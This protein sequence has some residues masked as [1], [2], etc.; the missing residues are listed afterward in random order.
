[1]TFASEGQSRLANMQPSTIRE[2]H[3]FAQQLLLEDPARKLLSLHFGES[4]QGTPAFI[5][6]A[7]VQ[8]L[9]NGAVF[10]ENNGGRED[11]KQALVEFYR[12]QHGVELSPAHFVVTCGATQ[13]ILLTMLAILVPGDEVFNI[14]P[15]WPNFTEAARISGAIVREVPLVFDEARSV[16]QLDMAELEKRIVAADAPRMVVVNSPSN[17]TGWIISTR[18]QEQ[19]FR[20]CVK[21]GLLLLSDEIYDRIVFND[22][23]SPTALKLSNELDHLVVVNGF[24]KTYCMTGWRLGYLITTPQRAAQMARM[25]EFVVSHAP[26]MAQVAA[27]AALRDGE[28]FIASSLERYRGL[29]QLVSEQLGALPGARVAR[30]EG[31]FYAFFKIPAAADSV[32]FCQQLV[33]ETG[34]VLAPGSAFGAGGEGWLRLCF[35]NTPE[36]LTSAIDKIHQLMT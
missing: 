30:T 36:R 22:E 23:R 32:A 5:V 3:D 35:A 13:A 11:L 4:D 33:K 2:V 7:A 25:Q 19:L 9:R 6:E 16:F 18:Q 29:R 17:P 12:R 21:H 10:Y 26:S 28:P 27:I 14:T 24:S 15:N 8:A 1:M 34:V 31:S 20:L